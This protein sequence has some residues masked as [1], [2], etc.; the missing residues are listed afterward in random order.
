MINEAVRLFVA[1]LAAGL[2]ITFILHEGV[3]GLATFFIRDEK[4]FIKFK[5]S[6]MDVMFKLKDIIYLWAVGTLI[7]I[8][9]GK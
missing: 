8:A 4:R 2:V 7:R 3:G 1:P 6:Y 9:V 5:E